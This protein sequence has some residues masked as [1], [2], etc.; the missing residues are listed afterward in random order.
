VALRAGG[1]LRTQER[2]FADKSRH[3]GGEPGGHPEVV[4]GVGGADVLAGAVGVVDVDRADVAVLAGLGDAAGAVHPGLAHVQQ[5]VAVVPADVDRGDA[6]VVGDHHVDQRHVAGVGDVVG[7]GHGAADG[8]VR[9]GRAVVVGAVGQLD[10]PDG[11][12]VAEVVVGVGVRDVLSGAVGVVG[13]GGA[14]LAGLAGGGRAASPVVPV[15]AVW[16]P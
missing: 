12:G 11:R 4:V 10:D 14:D 8:H 13:I 16:R 1:H 9:A 7:P 5:A 2:N 3:D 6:L 15:L